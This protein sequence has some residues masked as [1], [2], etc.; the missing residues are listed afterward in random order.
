MTALLLAAL[1][2]V[3]L[4]WTR[5]V[6]MY[7]DVFPLEIQPLQALGLQAAALALG[8][9]AFACAG[10]KG[11]ARLGASFGLVMSAIGW[12]ASRWPQL[13]RALDLS[14][15][16]WIG[17]FLGGL[18]APALA[19]T[20]AAAAAALLLKDLK[21][22]ALLL[23]V[24]IAAL[25]A[26][27]TLVTEASLTRW[28]GLGPRSLAEAAGIPTNADAQIADVVRL[29]PSRGRTTTRESVKMASSLQDLRA[30]EP[31]STG[32]DLSP[33]SIAKL[34]GFLQRTGY[35]DVFAR[36]ALAHVRRGWLMWWDAD[37]AL[38]AMMIAVPGRAVPDYR[39]ALDLIKIGPMTAERFAKLEQLDA[40]ATADPRTGFE[41]VTASQYIFEGFAAAYARFGDEAK[42]RRWLGHIDNLLLVTEKKVEVAALEDF[43][44]GQ[45]S[46]SLTLDGRPAGG[47]MVGLFEIWRTT[48]TASGV[49]LLSGSTFPDADGRFVFSDLGPG[50]Y[51]L[52]LLGRPEDLRGRVIGSPGRFDVGYEHPSVALLPIAIER[53]VLPTP[54]A[55]APGGLPDAPQPETPEPPLLWRKR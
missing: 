4:A 46:G 6:T 27:P 8:A 31:P 32:V 41:Q 34:E 7:P 22:R 33:E 55:F 11:R 50:E 25:W 28:W 43:R 26:V 48:P 17:P 10:G 14:G 29:S 24:W 38:D 18:A 52:S 36:E 35:R 20:A 37:H 51:E 49:R 44:T 39:G 42:A 13:S 9:A 54:Q 1:S 2:W 3:L 5:D 15:A 16:T 23:V 45:I 19:V 40:A 12:C 53:D 30:D 21:P 47:V